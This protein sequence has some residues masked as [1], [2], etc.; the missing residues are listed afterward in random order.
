[1]K[2]PFYWLLLLGAL[3]IAACSSA[4]APVEPPVAEN[5]EPDT[6]VSSSSSS[7]EA[8]ERFTA[9]R[10]AEYEITTDT[11]ENNKV[12][13]TATSAHNKE[14][15][16]RWTVDRQKNVVKQILTVERRHK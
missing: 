10:Y 9:D 5:D 15:Q 14:F 8:N 16:R 11:K 2:R 1:M 13:I 12:V 6:A 4:G 3:F 7:S